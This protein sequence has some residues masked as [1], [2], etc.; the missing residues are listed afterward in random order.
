MKRAPE[1]LIVADASPLGVGA[2]LAVADPTQTSF[3]PLAAF[4]A[5][6]TQEVRWSWPCKTGDEAA[7]HFRPDPL[8]LRG[9][10]GHGEEAGGE[11][12]SAQLLGR[13]G[14]LEPRGYGHLRSAG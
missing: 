6:V 2:V 1:F 9:R 14:G 11:L 4:K 3:E 13:M 7:G 8:R 5:K 10:L 12:A